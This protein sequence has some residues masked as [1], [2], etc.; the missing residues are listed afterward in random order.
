MTH[1]LI[2][3]FKAY[4]EASLPHLISFFHPPK[5]WKS[6]IASLAGDVTWVVLQTVPMQYLLPLSVIKYNANKN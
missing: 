4:R 6:S 1:A 3:K 5:Y 2:V